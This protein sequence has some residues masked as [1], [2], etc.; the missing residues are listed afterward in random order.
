M[1]RIISF[2]GAQIIAGEDLDIFH[3]AALNVVDG[4]IES[5]GSP[6]AQGEQVA[7]ESSLILPMFINAHC[8]LGDTGAKELGVGLPMEEVVSPPNGLK[9]RFLNQLSREEHIS[10]MRDGLCE[11]LANGIIACADFR[12]QGLDGSLRLREA[13]AG[14][15][16]QVKIL[17]R[18]RETSTCAQMYEE[19]VQLLAVADGLGI[20]DVDCYPLQLLQKLRMEYPNKL[21]AA[22]AAENQ[23][24]ERKSVRDFGCGQAKRSLEFGPD[25]LVH[26]THTSKAE[27]EELA[28]AKVH[29][30]SCPRANSILGD[31]LPD[32]KSWLDAGVQFGLGTDNMMASSADMFREMEYSSRLTRGMN[33]EANAIDSKTVLKSATI[34]GARALKFDQDLGSLSPGKMASF[35]VLDT[36]CLNLKYCKDLI[37]AVVNRADVRDIKSIYIE[38][39]KYK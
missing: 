10:Q 24:V 7:L 8:H 1:S 16:L 5:I 38:G 28:S 25:F 18:F 15:P 32:L 33:L 36:A 4:R 3:G 35:I 27:L 9:H 20:R 31:G 2:T 13:A 6:I 14:L 22:H 26:L 12:E 34:Q 39:E 30:V 23:G 19:A 21:F 29:A 17:G 11:M 37:S